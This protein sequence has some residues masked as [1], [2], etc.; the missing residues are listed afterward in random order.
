MI[1]NHL[2]IKLVFAVCGKISLQLIH[3]ICLSPCLEDVLREE[4]VENKFFLRIIL[5]LDNFIPRLLHL[6]DLSTSDG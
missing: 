5:T 1:L 4:S 2:D 6:D 3:Q